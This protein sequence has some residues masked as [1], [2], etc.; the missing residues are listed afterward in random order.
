MNF[1][2][3]FIA[4]SMFVYIRSSYFLVLPTFS[5]PTFIPTFSVPTFSLPLPTFIP[6]FSVPIFSLPLPT[7]SLPS[8]AS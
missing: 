1:L 7:F 2:S 8:F 3:L 4:K 6:T 5:L